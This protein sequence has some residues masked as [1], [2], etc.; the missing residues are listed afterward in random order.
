MLEKIYGSD[1]IDLVVD[2]LNMSDVFKKKTIVLGKNDV[3]RSRRLSEI[4][5]KISNPKR[6]FD[7]DYQLCEDALEAAILARMLEKSR[8]EVEGKFDRALR[9]CKKMNNRRQLVR[10]HYQRAWTYINWYDDHLEFISQYK[11]FKDLLIEESNIAEIELYFNLIN[12]MRGIPASEEINVEAEIGGFLEIL[13]KY[14]NNELAPCSSLIAK[15]YSLL[16]KLITAFSSREDPKQYII[17]LSENL[18][19][20]VYFL[21]F[22]F[23]SFRKIIDVLGK[24][25]TNNG[26]FDILID[27]VASLLEKRTSELAAGEVFLSRGFQKLK[28]SLFKDSI[29][30]FGKAIFKL[31]KKESQ[32]KL[33]FSLV[34]LSNAYRAFGLMWASN[35]CLIA[36]TSMSIKSWYERGTMS[37]QFNDCIEQFAM[38]ELIIGRVPAFLNWHELF[39]V[40]SKYR[41]INSQNNS[42]LELMDAFFS[43]RI[44]NTSE[45]NVN[46]ISLLPDLLASQDLVLSQDAS[47]FWLGYEEEIIEN[48]RGLNIEK[49]R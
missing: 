21:D 2:S 20:S 4:E 25:F 10:L 30:Y 1:L 33:Y 44:L 6:Y 31:S 32:D 14:E 43:V 8:D 13:A 16:V 19:S 27:T 39:C 9:L 46:C 49:K 38:N 23:E 15:C 35:N 12:L 17:R 47:L 40:T 45:E 34:G 7:V 29:V 11:S 28:S 36:A 3:E 48:Y 26:D 24:F 5:T 37:E 18:E 42:R 41:D 22:P